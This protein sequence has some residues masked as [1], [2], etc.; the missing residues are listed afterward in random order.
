QRS[1]RNA[2]RRTEDAKVDRRTGACK[3]S[4]ADRMQGDDCR[5][6]EHRV[7]TYPHAEIAAFKKGE[8]WVHSQASDLCRAA[9]AIAGPC[10]RSE[11]R[12]SHQATP[13]RRERRF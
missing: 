8:K 3:E 4:H 7:A 1:E 9:S 10:V 11:A 5:K 2:G 12:R 13:R 6:G